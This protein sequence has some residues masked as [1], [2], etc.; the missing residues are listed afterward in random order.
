MIQIDIPIF[1]GNYLEDLKVI[2][3]KKN[4][5]ILALSTLADKLFEIES[6]KSELV[7]DLIKSW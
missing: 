3:C 1:D 2:L 6:I 7:S 5:T 4:I